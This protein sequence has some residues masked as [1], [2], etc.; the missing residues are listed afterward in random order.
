MVFIDGDHSYAGCKADIK[1]WLPHIKPGGLLVI[2][3]YKKDERYAQ[4]IIGKAPH[5]KAWHG[6]DRA[7]DQMLTG[8]YEVAGRVDT[9][10]AF[11]IVETTD[12][13]KH[14]VATRKTAR[15]MKPDDG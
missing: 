5:P 9:T 15:R 7:V 11:R 12:L 10:I 6:V 1:A 13:P 8:K 14:K 2:H 4:P 3:D